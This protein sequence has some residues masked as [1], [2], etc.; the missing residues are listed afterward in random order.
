M[1]IK[2]AS[3]L[4]GIPPGNTNPEKPAII[5]NFIEGVWRSGDEGTIVTDYHPVDADVAVVQ[6]FVHANSKNSPHL[7]LRKQVFEKQ[8]KDKKRSIIVD[9]NL[10]LFADPKNT[11]KYLRYSYDGI[12]PSTGEY[13]NENP[14]PTRWQKISRD[15]HLN[16]QP[17]KK[18]S[19]KNFT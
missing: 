14:D 5:V 9:S 17:Y 7:N 8:K 1:T 3:Y 10:F 19:G 15:L 4:M 13:C 12:F 2:V 6:G 18:D 11:K 16:L